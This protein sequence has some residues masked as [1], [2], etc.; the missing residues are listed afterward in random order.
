VHTYVANLLPALM[1]ATTE[2]Q[3]FL[4]AD[5]KRPFELRE[6]PRHVTVRLSPYRNPLSSVAHDFGMRNLMARDRLDVVHFPANYGFAPQGVRTVITLHDEINVMPLT[7]IWRGHPKNLR[8]FGMMTYLHFCSTAAVRRADWLITVSAYAAR[9]IARYSKFDSQ[10]IAPVHHAPTADLHREQDTR[11]LAE[12]CARHNVTRPFVLADAL[13]NPGV[14]VRA[15][16]LLS[17]EL[18]ARYEI[19]FF[20]RRPDV[21]PIVPEAVKDG[22]ARL[23]VRPSRADLIALYSMAQAFVFPSWIEGFGLPILEAM[24]CG[25]PV[26]AS[27]RGAIPEVAGDAALITDAED[28]ASLAQYLTRVLSTPSLADDLRARGFAR[29]AQFSWDKTARQV[30]DCYTRAFMLTAARDPRVQL[31]QARPS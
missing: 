24:T 7:E 19:V 18:R 23:L 25:A 17:D 4:Y 28:A 20:A 15:W 22:Q 29:A 8:T 27:N 26:I 2:H 9:E 1:N 13:K 5:T 6:V 11:V 16:R 30:L 31:E 10:K 3:L 21:L 14:L 12:V